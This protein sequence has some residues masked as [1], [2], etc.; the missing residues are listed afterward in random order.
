MGSRIIKEEFRWEAI[1]IYKIFKALITI[2]WILDILNF[3][4]LEF[5]DRA[6]PVN[7]LAWILI[8]IFLPSD[9]PIVSC[10]EKSEEGLY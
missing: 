7:T 3:T 6:Y 4:Q 9:N 8:F 1:I 5:L 10:K 2:V